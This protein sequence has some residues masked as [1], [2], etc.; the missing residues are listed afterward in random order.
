[1]NTGKMLALRPDGLVR[2]QTD[3]DTYAQWLVWRLWIDMAKLDVILPQEDQNSTWIECLP[4]AE[5]QL[6]NFLSE[7]YRDMYQHPKKYYIP[8]ENY[9][10]FVSA[11]NI[12]QETVRHA[13]LQVKKAVV[14]CILDF[15]YEVGRNSEINETGLWMAGETYRKLLQEKQKKCKSNSFLTLL[16]EMGFII[17]DEERIHISHNEYPLMLTSLSLF[18]KECARNKEYGFYFFCKCDFQVFAQKTKPS[19]EDA[20]KLVPEAY[21]SNV[22]TLD[23]FLIQQKFKR[24]VLISE[25]WSGYRIR[26]RRNSQMVVWCRVRN[27]FYPD[28]LLQLRWKM[29]QYITSQL[30]QR[31]EDREPGFAVK[32]LEGIHS[33]EG[34]RELCSARSELVWNGRTWIVCSENGWTSSHSL[35]VDS[36]TQMK[37]LITTFNEVFKKDKKSL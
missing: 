37:L 16:E 4:E 14:T 34:C 13:I 31:L 29:D 19:F 33:C 2:G 25:A 5:I 1:M 3:F 21:Q 23:E 35:S 24:E 20:M 9:E 7:L 32:T 22:I 30:L 36:F 27:T 28:L 12:E 17:A 10:G 26:Y 15:L 11:S 8:E 6:H 18:S